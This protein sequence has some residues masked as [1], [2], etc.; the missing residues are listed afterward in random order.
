MPQNLDHAFESNQFKEELE[1]HGHSFGELP[2]WMFQGLVICIDNKKIFSSMEQA[3]S[4]AFSL[5]YRQ[6]CN[7]ASFAG[8][9]TTT[10]ITN[11]HITHVLVGENRDGIRALRKQ[12][13]T[14]IDICIFLQA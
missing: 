3:P 2:G 1:Q 9:E 13:S 4:P 7:T 14:Y 5:R 10:D 11:R 12:L 8:A 6:A